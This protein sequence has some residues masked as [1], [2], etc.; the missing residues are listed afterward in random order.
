MAQAMEPTKVWVVLN[1]SGFIDLSH[2]FGADFGALRVFANDYGV[3]EERIFSRTFMFPK[4]RKREG[5]RAILM[6]IRQ[7]SG[8]TEAAP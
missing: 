3:D 1:P 2:A 8:T 4:T 6:E 5:Y 7:C